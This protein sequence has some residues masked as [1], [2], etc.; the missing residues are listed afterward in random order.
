MDREIQRAFKKCPFCGDTIVIE[1][2]KCRYCGEWVDGRTT[3]SALAKYSNAQPVRHFL[4][5]SIITVSF[6]NF[7]WFY[8]TWRQLREQE[9]WDISP[10]WRL[11]GLFIPILNLYLTYNLFKNIRD[12]ASAKDCERLY[13]L[14]WML[15]VWILISALASLPAPYWLMSLLIVLPMG[16]VQNVLNIYWTKT[17]PNLAMRTSLSKEQIV[18]LILGAVFWIL[19]IIGYSSPE[20]F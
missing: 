1:A 4:L 13:S 20:Y 18:L 16:V 17:Q 10:G 8:R 15:I 14:G 9:K 2:V 3:S 6:Y 19:F 11:V 7:Y 5:L 12:F